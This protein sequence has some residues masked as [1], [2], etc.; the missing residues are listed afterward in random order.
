[1]V[2]LVLVLIFVT[3]ERRGCSLTPIGTSDAMLRFALY[4]YISEI[5][6]EILIF[7]AFWDFWNRITF[8]PSFSERYIT[9]D[10][11][12]AREHPY[13]D[14]REPLGLGGV[15][16]DVVED[17]DQHEEERDQEGHAS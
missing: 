1:M 7:F 9:E 13:L 4:L 17:V 16:R 6:G 11:E 8:F 5:Q 10:K 2:V 3:S 12:D 14:G 15:G